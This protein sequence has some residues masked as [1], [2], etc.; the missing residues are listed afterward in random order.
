MIGSAAVSNG[1]SGDG[2][3]FTNSATPITYVWKDPSSQGRLSRRS[4]TDPLALAFAPVSDVS[5]IF[6]FNFVIFLIFY[7]CGSCPNHGSSLSSK[8]IAASLLARATP[9]P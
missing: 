3:C 5:F 4:A 1:E 6:N 2:L 8:L 7:F 9:P